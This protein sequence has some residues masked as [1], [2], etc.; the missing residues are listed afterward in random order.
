MPTWERFIHYASEA[1]PDIDRGILI[2]V[3]GS[4]INMM[5]SIGDFI[6]KWEPP[7]IPHLLIHAKAKLVG[8][9]IPKTR[10]VMAYITVDPW[11]HTMPFS[12]ASI[13]S[14]I[15][16]VFLD[17]GHVSLTERSFQEIR[18]ST[19]LFWVSK[20]NQKQRNNKNSGKFIRAAFNQ[21]TKI[22]IAPSF[23]RGIF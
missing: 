13:H 19:R 23:I 7:G 16:N 10:K 17:K 5:M 6:G 3:L 11:L 9:L 22:K 15:R 20:K 21:N 2:I 8:I 18:E 14:R 4:I 1:R 12:M